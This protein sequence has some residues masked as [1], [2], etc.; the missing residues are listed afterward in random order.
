MRLITCIL[1]AALLILPNVAQA[2]GPGTEKTWDKLTDTSVK[3]L[4][5]VQEGKFDEAKQL[6]EYFG[7]QFRKSQK[8]LNLSMKEL[9][10]LT[11]THDH[12]MRAVV[13]A[14]ASPETRVTIV[15]QFH[16][17]VDA[18]HSEND[19]LWL[20]TKSQLFTPFY[21]MKQAAAQKDDRAYQFYLNQFLSKYEMI[22]PALNVDLKDPIMGRLESEIAYLRNH[23]IDYFN[24]PNYMQHLNRVEKDFRA[25]YDGT[26]DDMMEPTLPWVIITIGGIIVLALSYAGWKKYRGERAEKKRKT[27]V[28]KR[29][30]S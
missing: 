7:K 3:A 19:P 10:I 24:E 12:A 13:N 8:E 18:L 14:S 20:S 1:F 22:H 28:K 5:L 17:V 23:R 16:L 30:K 4:Q 9:R 6:L 25:L 29:S 27:K 26:L 15:T 21:K 2:A 11:A